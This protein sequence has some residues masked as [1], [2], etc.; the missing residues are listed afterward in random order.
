VTNAS[1]KRSDF[2]G[3]VGEA[4]SRQGPILPLK[5]VFGDTHEIEDLL[6]WSFD[7]CA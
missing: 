6:N 2:A 1:K 5:I 3:A 7:D 4:G